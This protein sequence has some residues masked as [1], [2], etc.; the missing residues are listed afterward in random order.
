MVKTTLTNRNMKDILNESSFEKWSWS[1][2]SVSLVCTNAGSYFQVDDWMNETTVAIC[3]TVKE[4][5][6]YF[7]AYGK[8]E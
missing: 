2:L 3:L 7:I 5:N 8:E 4:L 6:K 1:M